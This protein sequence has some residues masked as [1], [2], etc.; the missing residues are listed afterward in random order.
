DELR[1]FA[2]RQPQRLGAGPGFDDSIAGL[3]QN[4][5]F[6]E[7]ADIAAIHVEDSDPRIIHGFLL[8]LMM[9]GVVFSGRRSSVKPLDARFAGAEKRLHICLCFGEMRTRAT[10]A[11]LFNLAPFT[12]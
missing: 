4:S 7:E 3:P 12:R 11:D 2:L 8:L 5:A 10:Q 6:S 1:R 9:R